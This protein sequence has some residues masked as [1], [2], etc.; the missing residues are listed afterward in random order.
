MKLL[1][2]LNL[3]DR[4]LFAEAM[5]NPVVSEAVLGIIMGEEIHLLDKPQTEKELRISPQL[6]SVRLDVYN[7]DEL[8]RLFSTE[9]Q[10]KNTGNLPRRGR[11]YQSLEDCSLLEP[12]AVDF[13][14][15]NDSFLITIAP[16]DLFGQGRYRYTFQMTCVEDPEVKLGDGQTR[17][18]LN[19]RGNNP[20]EVSTE[21]VELLRYIENTSDQTAK[22]CTSPSV[23][24]IHEQIRKIKL[25]E[26]MGVKYMQAWEEKVYERMEGKEEGRAEGKANEIRIIRKKLEK[27]LSSAEIAEI[28]EVEE[29]YISQIA[30][31]CGSYPDESDQEIAARYF[32]EVEGK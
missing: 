2:D 14:L 23:R 24:K 20:D 21:L 9:M 4:F 10:G 6:R 29:S 8:R 3:L 17:I 12:G 1:K 31:L 28:L 32:K 30:G 15:L 18:F 7:M 22:Q 27:G 11:Y 25:S 26:E 5:D 19:T 16:F 13:N